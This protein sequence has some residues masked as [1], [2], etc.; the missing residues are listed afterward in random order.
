MTIK[1]NEKIDTK[2]DN[3][4]SLA[5]KAELLSTTF[6]NLANICS[7]ISL[8]NI[9]KTFEI[10]NKSLE[11][12]QN[13]LSSINFSINQENF[14]NLMKSLSSNIKNLN[15]IQ[16]GSKQFFCIPIFRDTKWPMFLYGNDIL[17]KQFASINKN[18]SQEVGEIVYKYVDNDFLDRIKYK[19][20]KCTFITD[21]K[22]QILLCAI[23]CYKEKNYIAC[24]SILQCQ[25]NGICLDIYQYIENNNIFF[26]ENS[27]YSIYSNLHPE[28]NASKKEV[29][30]TKMKSEKNK[31]LIAYNSINHGCLI[32]YVCIEYLYN[33]IYTS[34]KDYNRDQPC[35]NK[36]CHGIQTNFNSYEHAIKSILAIDLMISLG[37]AIVASNAENIKIKN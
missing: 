34:R 4:L 16:K 22:K 7:E 29:L 20:K 27:V 32:W 37:N 15:I 35:R 8:L 6:N 2:K 3:D 1:F 30:N 26:D 10:A 21:E 11:E 14:N 28:D 31:L 25:M 18:N 9:Q 24:V 12:F 5:E 36:I 13:N 19:W 17:F 23:N 33:E